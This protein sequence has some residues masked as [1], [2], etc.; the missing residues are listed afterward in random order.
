M[1]VDAVTTAPEE[2]KRRQQQQ[3]QHLQTR[4]LSTYQAF[5][6]ATLPEVKAEMLGKKTPGETRWKPA[7]QN[8][9]IRAVGA[10]W[11][12]LTDAQKEGFS[13]QTVPRKVKRFS[14]YHAFFKA[15]LAQV[16]REMI[17]KKKS[18]EKW[19]ETDQRNA[20]KEVGARWRANR[21][22]RVPGTEPLPAVEGETE[23]EASKR[24]VANRKRE[25]RQ[26]S[27]SV[28]PT[29]ILHFVS[30]SSTSNGSKRVMRGSTGTR[31]SVRLVPNTNG[32]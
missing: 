5:L 18:G 6:R 27:C 30:S 21:Q 3:Q 1:D 13:G 26:R 8:D 28:K 16:K 19:G 25:S 23:E 12:E 15:T 22:R 9:A 29:D 14:A 20:V 7:D 31:T 2:L 32:V 17:G 24:E 10:R 11:R 4:T